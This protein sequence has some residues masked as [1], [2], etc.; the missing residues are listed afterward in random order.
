M[1]TNK[2]IPSLWFDIKNSVRARK[3]IILLGQTMSWKTQIVFETRIRIVFVNK[4]R[5]GEHHV[6]NCK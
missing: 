5:K 2:I 6:L 1:N 3:I 4:E